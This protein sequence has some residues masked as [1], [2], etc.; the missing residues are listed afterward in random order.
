MTHRETSREIDEAAA[1]WVARIDRSPLSAE[2]QARF[3]A[4]LG[5]GDARRLG[6]YARASAVMAHAERSR[7]LGGG[8]APDRADERGQEAGVD[9]RRLMWGSALAAGL[10]GAAYLGYGRFAGAVTV[11]TA[12]GEVRR[13]P[14]PD[15]SSATLNTQSLMRIAYSG[16]SR[17]IELVRGEALFD[18]A[19]DATR[20]FIVAAGAATVRAVGTSFTVRRL[21]KGGVKVLVRE[22]V[23]DI[24]DKPTSRP[25]RLGANSVATTSTLAAAGRTDAVQ[26]AIRAEALAP[27]EVDRGLAWKDGLISFDGVTLAAAASEFSRYSDTRIVIDDPVLARETVT[28][29]FSAT[30]PVGFANAVATSFNGRATRTSGEVRLAR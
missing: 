21:E 1:R 24:A 9:R 26:P 2:E 19:K 27:T 29:L 13:V 10:A 4:W 23:V 5:T 11:S 28:G 30:D 25:L 16:R 12:K 8:A 17:R 22:G 15:G 6:A 7:A 18:V 14:L 3:D 20:P